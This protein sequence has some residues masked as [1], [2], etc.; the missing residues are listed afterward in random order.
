MATARGSFAAVLA[1]ISILPMSGARAEEFV[2]IQS[3]VTALPAGTTVGPD[4]ALD[5]P[6]QDRIVVIGA[7]GRVVAVD[8]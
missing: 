2:I 7:S 1:F 3:S 5:V 6:A 4:M 8:G